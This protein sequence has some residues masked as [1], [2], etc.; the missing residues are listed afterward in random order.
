MLLG[1]AGPAKMIARRSATYSSPFM[2]KSLSNSFQTANIPDH[3]YIG[4]HCP[5]FDYEVEARTRA[6]ANDQEQDDE[7]DAYSK[8]FDAE[9][10]AGVM[11]EPAKDH[12]E[13]KWVIVWKG[14]KMF[15]DYRRRVNYCSPDR[16]GMYIYNDFE[17]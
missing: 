11:L 1:P 12:P 7:H 16:F 3:E 15:M 9:N 10:K 13:H 6:H 8:G 4:M 5:R 17:G 14:F 2:F